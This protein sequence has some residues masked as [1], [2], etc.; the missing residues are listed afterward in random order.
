MGDEQKSMV[1][2][3]N[4]E[5]A[6]MREANQIVA[7]T[8]ARVKKYVEPGITTWELDQIAEDMCL[9]KECTTCF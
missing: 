3:S 7:E 9:S 6:L 2:K 5:I 1:V 8:L 4:D